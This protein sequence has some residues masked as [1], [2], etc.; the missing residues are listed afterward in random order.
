[1]VGSHGVQPAATKSFPEFLAMPRVAQRRR[2]DEVLAIEAFEIGRVE[3]Q[4]LG[5][6][7]GADVDA[8]FLRGTDSGQSRRRTEMHD[9]D[10]GLDEF[11]QRGGAGRRLTFEESGPCP[12]VFDHAGSAREQRFPLQ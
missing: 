9:V 10:R 8:A 12:T 6:G 4:V 7:F 1:M 2:A 3:M 5:A 11:G